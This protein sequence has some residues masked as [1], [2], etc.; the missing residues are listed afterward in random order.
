MS[1][2]IGDKSESIYKII[3]KDN[4]LGVSLEGHSNEILLKCLIF[5]L[6]LTLN[7]NNS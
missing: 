4:G 5:H 6:I 2:Q 7:N 1:Q 3:K